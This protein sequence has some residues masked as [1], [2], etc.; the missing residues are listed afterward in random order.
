MREDRRVGDPALT[1]ETLKKERL[2]R[3]D[4][5][6][7]RSSKQGRFRPNG[8]T[9]ETYKHRK[10]SAWRR[11]FITDPGEKDSGRSSISK[12]TMPAPRHRRSGPPS[13]LAADI[14]ALLRDPR[15]SKRFDEK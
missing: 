5:G 1:I 3:C 2:R 10:R 6:M 8:I 14:T 7:S 9:V 12:D 11:A 15:Y 4:C 13:P